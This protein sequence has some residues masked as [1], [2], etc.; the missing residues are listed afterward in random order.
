MRRLPLTNQRP[1]HFY[2]PKIRPFWVWAGRFYNSHLLRR[3]NRVLEV[4]IEGVEHLGPLLKTGDG[5]LITPNHTEDADCQVVFELAR[6]VGWPFCYMAAYQIF[7]G[8]NHGFLSRIGVFPVD[9]EGTDLAAFKAAVGVLEAGRNPLVIF[10]EGETYHQMDRLTP[11]R[12]G[13]AVIAATAAKK[14]AKTGR[15]VWIVPAAIKYRFLGGHNPLPTLETLMAALEARYVWRPRPERS[16]IERIYRYGEGTLG[17]LELDYLGDYRSGP[18]PER[19][20]ALRDHILA[21][22]E[23]RRLGR[24]GTE[25]APVRVKELRRACLEALADP[26]TSAVEAERL[27]R[28]LDDLF[29]VVQLFSYPGDYVRES[30]TLERVAETLTKA[31]GGRPRQPIAPPARP[32]S[33]APPP[34]R[35]DRRRSIPQRSRRQAPQ[36]RPDP[37][38]R[39]RAAN[40]RA[41]RRDRPR[42]PVAIE[43]LLKCLFFES[44]GVVSGVGLNGP[45]PSRSL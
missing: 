32:P 26:S 25:P 19:L 23:G 36:G 18:L 17:L 3:Q 16:L 4:A 27:R 21:A 39:P 8:V 6:R 11:L 5:V 24:P 35:T 14:R 43:E 41:A 33:G 34:R 40:A 12:E 20:E 28:D 13:A 1:Y 45:R 7:S 31:G 37:D 9:R 2:P 29:V 44:D 30:P 38:H 10:P 15:T 22:I 42:S